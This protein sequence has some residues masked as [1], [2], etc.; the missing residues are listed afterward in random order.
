MARARQH[1]NFTFVRDS[2]GQLLFAPD[3]RH[4]SPSVED[5]PNLEEA[6]LLE[7]S[8]VARRTAAPRIRGCQLLRFVVFGR[9]AR[10]APVTLYFEQPA[11]TTL[12]DAVSA[13]ATRVSGSAQ[14]F[15]A[16][17]CLVFDADG[18][19]LP[20]CSAED[21][22]S[23]CTL[24]GLCFES[25]ELLSVLP[26]R[27]AAAPATCPEHDRI[28]AKMIPAASAG[29]QQRS[30]SCRG[31]AG[32]ETVCCE[33]D[34]QYCVCALCRDTDAASFLAS[35]VVVRDGGTGVVV[36]GDENEVYARADAYT[37]HFSARDVATRAVCARSHRAA[38]AFAVRGAA[39]G[40]RPHDARAEEAA[41]VAR[42]ALHVQ[43]GAVSRAARAAAA[44]H[45]AVARVQ[46]GARRRLPRRHGPDHRRAQD[47]RRTGAESSVRARVARAVAP[48]V[49]RGARRGLL[50]ARAA[51]VRVVRRAI[52]RPKTRGPL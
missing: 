30:C 2:S 41:R 50:R 18:A 19:P 31:A 1:V 29:K 27:D 51:A 32:A 46:G 26:L 15:D 39:R 34:C 11:S 6:S 16:A 12:F 33:K 5:A 13:F 52:S 21:N 36:E 8:E 25:A 47:L 7:D 9:G 37:E 43:R 48:Q 10:H 45:V 3:R 44:G 24:A 49:L 35:R 42:V 14:A 28:L 4:H 38:V 20:H 23:S 22:G 40:A 17:S